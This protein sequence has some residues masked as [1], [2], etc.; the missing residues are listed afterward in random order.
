MPS[1]Y[2]P[3]QAK[4]SPAVFGTFDLPPPIAAAHYQ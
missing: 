3:F 4:K 1:K 2:S